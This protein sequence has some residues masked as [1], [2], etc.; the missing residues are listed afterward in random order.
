[1][2]GRCP[3]PIAITL[4]S[5]LIDRLAA[6]VADRLIVRTTPPATPYLN[7]DQAAEYLACGKRRVYDLVEREAVVFFRDGKRLLFRR[8][9]LDAY[10]AAPREGKE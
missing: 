7:V 8:A 3:L 10:V 4:S 2:K 6:Q 5:A 9:D 1:M